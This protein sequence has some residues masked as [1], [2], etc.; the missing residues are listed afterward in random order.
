MKCK[1]CG[2]DFVAKNPSWDRM[3]SIE[4][5]KAGRAVALKKYRT[6]EKYRKLAQEWKK[7]KTGKAC[8]RRYRKGGRWK[9]NF[10]KAKEKY[11]KNNPWVREAQKRRVALYQRC[12][13]GK[14]MEWWEKEKADGCRKCGT[15]KNLWICHKKLICNG[16]G[17]EEENLMCLC[18]KCCGKRAGNKRKNK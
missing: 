11:E 4:C 9:I 13:K 18:R 10:L 5:R 3:C 17:E 6:S 12:T 16:G 8:E 14:L 1:F 2:N 15:F 7:T